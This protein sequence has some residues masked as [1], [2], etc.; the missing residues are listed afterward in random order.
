[1][2]LAI[3]GC[4]HS[5]PTDPVAGPGGAGGG[6]AGGGTGGAPPTATFHV[7]PQGNDDNDCSEAAPCRTLQYAAVVASAEGSL[8]LVADGEYAGFHSLHDRVTFRAAGDAAVVS[9]VVGDALDLIEVGS[10]G[11][12]VEGFV[13]RGAPRAGIRV[14]GCEDVVIRGNRVADSAMWGILTGFAPRVRIVGNETYG[15]LGEHGIYVGNS[16]VEDDAPVIAGNHSHDNQGN[17]IQI[18][19]DCE[20][21]GDGTIGGALVEGNHVHH[22][23]QK[24]LSM[25]SAPRVRIVNNVLHDNGSDGGAAGIHLVN[26]PNCDEALSTR[27]GVVVN[28]TVV[29]PALTAIR[30]NDGATGNLVFNNLLVSATP[31]S[32]EVGG[33]QEASNYAEEDAGVFAFDALFRPAAGSPAA[34]AGIASFTTADAP[35]T[36]YDGSERPRGVAV[37]LGAFEIE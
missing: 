2:A 12:T 3:V 23:G 35:S 19:G 6:G 4:T 30:M 1:V 22:N 33:N 14:A 16:N 20:A 11:V 37:D 17:G 36:D 18:N 9:S 27:D 29:E 28:N 13:V 34:D 26:Q 32:D 21:G 31:L 8:V 24:G 10:D 25:I 7:S 15:T 5:D